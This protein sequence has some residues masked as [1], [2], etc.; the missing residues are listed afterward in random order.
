MT[1][2]LMPQAINLPRF[3]RL[4][5]LAV[6]MAAMW[7]A[8]AQE[9]ARMKV[10]TTFSILADFARN[11]G[12]DRVEVTS[13]VGPNGDVHVYAPT[14]SDVQAVKRAKLVIINGLGLEGWLPRLIESS[15]TSAVSVAATR[16]IVPR[17]V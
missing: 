12:G 17:Q 2:P 15:A 11:V 1:R 4:F 5:A 14:A 7:P 6:A 10:V 13:L 8:S 16:G 3:F 9:A